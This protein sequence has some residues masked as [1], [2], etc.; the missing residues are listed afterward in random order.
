MFLDHIRT[1]LIYGLK[2]AATQF[3]A[4]NHVPK[5]KRSKAHTRINTIRS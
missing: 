3:T 1:L 4:A 5:L 2:K